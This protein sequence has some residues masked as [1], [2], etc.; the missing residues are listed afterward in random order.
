MPSFTQSVKQKVS[1]T[2]VTTLARNL[3]CAESDIELF[4]E[5]L[6]QSP[7]DDP[8]R[9]VNPVYSM[10]ISSKNQLAEGA[11]LTGSDNRPSLT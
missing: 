8:L 11:T 1:Y 3:N 9:N 2:G 5:A 4:T 7:L 6:S 10:S